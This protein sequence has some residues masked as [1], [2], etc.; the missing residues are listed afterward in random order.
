MT[1]H[2]HNQKVKLAAEVRATL[3][4]AA[5]GDDPRIF[6]TATVEQFN[7]MM[8]GLSSRQMEIAARI[9]DGRI[10]ISELMDSN[11]RLIDPDLGNTP[12]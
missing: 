1:G 7:K 9:R 3:S 11:G 8:Y 4:A 10:N 5:V 12:E 6:R 2:N